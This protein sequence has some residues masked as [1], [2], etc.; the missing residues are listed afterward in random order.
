MINVKLLYT[1]YMQHSMAS[2]RITDGNCNIR[3][4]TCFEWTSFNRGHY[5]PSGR[6]VSEVSWDLAEL[7]YKHELSVMKSISI[8]SFVFL[9]LLLS[10]SL[11]PSVPLHLLCLSFICFLMCSAKCNSCT[12]CVG[13]F[14]L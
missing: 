10:P 2:Y 13:N 3:I 9:K 5:S 12:I 6:F 1:V 8:Q 7:L 14:L 4:K 11:P